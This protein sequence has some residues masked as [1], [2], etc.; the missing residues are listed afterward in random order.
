MSERQSNQFSLLVNRTIQRKPA[1]SNPL[2]HL[3]QMGFDSDVAKAALKRT[4]FKVD[5]ALSILKLQ[6]EKEMKLAAAIKK[7]KPKTHTT[8]TQCHGAC[9]N[10]AVGV[11][12]SRP[13]PIAAVI[14]TDTEED[15]EEEE[16]EEEEVSNTE[17]YLSSQQNKPTD[18]HDR[19]RS[20]RCLYFGVNGRACRNGAN[21]AFRHQLTR[22]QAQRQ[23]ATVIAT[24][25]VTIGRDV[26]YKQKFGYCR[27]FNSR[28]G[29]R[30]GAKCR[31]SHTRPLETT[32][33]TSRSNSPSTGAD[34]TD[35]GTDTDSV[36]VSVEDNWPELSDYVQTQAETTL[37]TSS[38]ITPNSSRC[39]V[40]SSNGKSCPLF[41]V[42][43]CSGMCKMHDD[44]AKQRAFQDQKRKAICERKQARLSP[45]RKPI[46][47]SV[48][49]VEAALPIATVAPSVVTPD[50]SNVPS[51]V[52]LPEQRP[53][54][55]TQT[56]LSPSVRVFRYCSHT[57]ALGTQCKLLCGDAGSTLCCDHANQLE[58]E[59][60]ST[61]STE[62]LTVLEAA[63]WRQFMAAM[64]PIPLSF[65]PV[66]PVRTP[67]VAATA[68]E[69]EIERPHQIPTR[70]PELL[71]QTVR[72]RVLEMLMVE[73]DPSKRLELASLL[74]QANSSSPW[75]LSTI[76]QASTTAQL[77]VNQL[78]DALLTMATIMS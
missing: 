69:V 43:G 31:F 72:K 3:T 20:M 9:D 12:T 36:S 33:A 2:L 17:Q 45:K 40:R 1:P 54:E 24:A 32:P 27:Y 42:A 47:Q 35:T 57:S 76:E 52:I 8:L 26:S 14:G 59:E 63:E 37:P 74:K 75:V 62:E 53:H 58:E 18:P 16:E 7:A 77:D 11:R 19:R 56:T 10:T 55:D 61:Q 21:C 23:P 15:Q 48:H 30:D 4:N 49:V 67:T 5:D 25:T 66:E 73:S 6:V 13:A 68:V 65:S 70:T 39:G 22:S 78:I 64:V 38:N 51:P 34:S 44:Q 28:M 60:Q 29:C 46:A 50:N 71:Q 41:A